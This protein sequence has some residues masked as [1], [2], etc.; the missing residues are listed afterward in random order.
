[1]NCVNIAKVNNKQRSLPRFK[2]RTEMA[3]MHARLDLLNQ[4]L[5]GAIART[6][7]N[8]ML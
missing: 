4:Q 1:M 2:V 3:K 7:F 5:D 8:M 6:A